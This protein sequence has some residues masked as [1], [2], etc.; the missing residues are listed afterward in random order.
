MS[1]PKSASRPMSPPKSM[2]PSISPVPT[3]TE[4][5]EKEMAM[6]AWA[7]GAIAGAVGIVTL[8][9][10]A[11]AFLCWRWRKHS[12]EGKTSEKSVLESDLLAKDETTVQGSHSPVDFLG[13]RPLPSPCAGVRPL[14][15]YTGV[16]LPSPYAESA[17][18]HTAPSPGPDGVCRSS[19]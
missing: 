10:V 14:S 17:M 11:M 19:N 18:A 1:P 4:K 6:S 15:P 5:V 7:T 2:S 16:V 12:P 13:G 3:L 8:L 9:G